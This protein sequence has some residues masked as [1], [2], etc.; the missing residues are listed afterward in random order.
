M[1]LINNNFNVFSTSSSDSESDSDDDEVDTRMQPVDVNHASPM[2]QYP[3]Q[4]ESV[5][6]HTIDTIKK[7]VNDLRQIA[8]V[9]QKTPGPTGYEWLFKHGWGDRCI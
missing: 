5:G 3:E 8:Q 2:E 7:E 6:F 9:I 1:S 4:S